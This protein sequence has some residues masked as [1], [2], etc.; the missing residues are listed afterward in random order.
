ML[1][2][3]IRLESPCEQGIEPSGSI[4]L[5]V[6][7]CCVPRMMLACPLYFCVGWQ[8]YKTQQY[9]N[10]EVIQPFTAIW[11]TYIWLCSGGN[12]GENVFLIQVACTM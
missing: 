9:I 12:W 2:W 11:E 4:N 10:E 6:S 8:S 3:W 7:E 1:M 5:G